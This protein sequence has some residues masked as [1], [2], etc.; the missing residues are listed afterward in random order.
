MLSDLCGVLGD[1]EVAGFVVVDDFLEPAL[2]PTTL[3]VP[4]HFGKLLQP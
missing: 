1:R 3:R 2:F 4:L